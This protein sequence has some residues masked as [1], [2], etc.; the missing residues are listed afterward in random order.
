MTG[1]DICLLYTSVSDVIEIAKSGEN[2]DSPVWEDVGGGILE[3]SENSVSNHFARVKADDKESV[4]AEIEKIFDGAQIIDAEDGEIG[5][6]TDEMT[7]KDFEN[8][9]NEL[10]KDIIS[11]CLLYTSTVRILSTKFHIKTLKK[12]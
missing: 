4:K 1:S 12:C 3:N 2:T 7:A 6:V 5:F 10:N 9:L 11:T 8:K